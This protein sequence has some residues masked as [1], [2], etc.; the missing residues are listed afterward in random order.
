MQDA[1]LS[2]LD[3]LQLLSFVCRTLAYA[4]SSFSSMDFIMLLLPS[5]SMID[6][7][8]ITRVSMYEG[9]IVPFGPWQYMTGTLSMSMLLCPHMLLLL[10]L[11]SDGLLRLPFCRNIHWSPPLLLHTVFTMSVSFVLFLKGLKTRSHLFLLFETSGIIP[12]SHI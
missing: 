2:C 8:E 5:H 6:I 1:Q 10:C 12:A 7:L 3:L 11:L 9:P 4:I